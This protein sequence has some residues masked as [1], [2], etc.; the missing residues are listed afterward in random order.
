MTTKTIP[1]PKTIRHNLLGKRFGRLSV[2]GYLGPS[3][4]RHPVWLCRCECGNEKGVEST[5]LTTGHSTSCG[6]YN[7]RWKHGMGGTP[8]HKTWHRIV[9]RCT[10]ASD[11]SYAHYGGRGIKVCERWLESFDAFYNDMGARPSPSHS[12]DRI[13]TN[14]DY[15]PGNCRWATASIQANNRRDNI[16]LTFRGRRM[17]AAQWAEEIGVPHHVVYHRLKQGWSTERTLT[18]PYTPRK[19]PTKR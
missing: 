6:C 1:V 17:S 7:P 16:F 10:K 2:I 3:K 14:G 18:Q 5:N 8:E 11:P 19:S 13:N 9:S 12:I 15:E 4:S